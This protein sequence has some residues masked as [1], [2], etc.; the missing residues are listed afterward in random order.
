MINHE[1]MVLSCSHVIDQGAKI[2]WIKSNAEDKES[3]E[4]FT[5]FDC[6]EKLEKRYLVTICRE[7]FIKDH[8]ISS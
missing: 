4:S 3:C 7:C 2:E 8:L 6:A 1:Q 5:C